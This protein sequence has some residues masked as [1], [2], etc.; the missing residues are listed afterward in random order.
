MATVKTER[1]SQRPEHRVTGRGSPGNGRDKW[2]ALF[3][4]GT[5]PAR[6][7]MGGLFGAFVLSC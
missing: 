4:R 1:S 7:S 3:G 2:S 5:A 6:R